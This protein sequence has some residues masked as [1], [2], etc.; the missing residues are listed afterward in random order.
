MDPYRVHRSEQERR[1]RRGRAEERWGRRSSYEREPVDPFE[2]REEAEEW[3]FGEGERESRRF[4]PEP[5]RGRGQRYDR[6]FEELEDWQRPR[7][8]GRPWDESQGFRR[9]FGQHSSA[10]QRHEENPYYGDRPSDPY[11]QP[12]GQGS[13]RGQGSW[14]GGAERFGTREFGPYR[15]ESLGERESTGYAGRGPKGYRRSD[16]RI[17]EDLSDRLTADPGIDASEISISVQQGEVTLEGTV[18]ERAMKRAAEDLA[19]EISGV[20]D[21]N[22]RLRVER[23]DGTEGGSGRSSFSQATS[24]QGLGSSS[25]S[26]KR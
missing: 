15:R 2:G 12:Y 4:A 22:N 8:L 17:R 26:E 24:S 6:G 13:M 3:E 11:F 16:E 25:R 20:R 21:V 19:E 1:G 18:S 10:G 23:Q 5:P 7:Q 9:E 14:G